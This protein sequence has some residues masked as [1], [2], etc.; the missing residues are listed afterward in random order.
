MV[1]AVKRCLHFGSHMEKMIIFTWRNRRHTN[2]RFFVSLCILNDD[3]TSPKSRNFYQ[4]C[5]A[6]VKN[7]ELR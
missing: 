1:M 3:C 2:F 4:V 7:Y 6:H 5:Q